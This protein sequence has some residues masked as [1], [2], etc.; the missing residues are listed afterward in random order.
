MNYTTQEDYNAEAFYQVSQENA[1]EVYFLAKEKG[2]V[3]AKG[4]LFD[5][6]YELLQNCNIIDPEKTAQVVEQ[7][8]E[9]REDNKCDAFNPFEE[10]IKDF[11]AKT[12]EV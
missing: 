11:K 8:Q 4:R 12:F 2:C 5:M 1:Y 6:L 7:W 3:Q 9:E 10:F